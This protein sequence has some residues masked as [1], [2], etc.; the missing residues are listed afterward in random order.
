MLTQNRHKRGN[1]Y[2]Q[3]ADLVMEVVS[4]DDGSRTP[5]LVKKKE[6][7]A[8][9]DIPEYWIVDPDEQH[10]RVLKLEAGEYVEGSPFHPGDAA[11]SN[12]LPGFEVDVTAVFDS[13][14][15]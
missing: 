11:A 8:K 9:A 7:Y 14:N 4:P 6:E 15:D 5:D 2:W 3:G 1:D 13:V 12:L 10:I